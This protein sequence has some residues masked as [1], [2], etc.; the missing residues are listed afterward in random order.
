MTDKLKIVRTLTGK[1]VSTKMDKTVTVLVGRSVKHPLIGKVI[2]LSSKFHAHDE[3]NEL[4]EGDVVEITEGRPLS[5]HKSWVVT[6]VISK[7]QQ[8]S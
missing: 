1:V 3:K 5:K 6:K 4:G 2:R 7:A 8:L